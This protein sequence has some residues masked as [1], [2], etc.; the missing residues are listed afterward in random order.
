MDN[1]NMAINDTELENVVGGSARKG[2]QANTEEIT[3]KAQCPFCNKKTTFIVYSG[4]RGKC[5]ECGNV[6]QI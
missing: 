2:K 1:K 6:S 5:K 3:A 4:S